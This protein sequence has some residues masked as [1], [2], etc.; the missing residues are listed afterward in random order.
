MGLSCGFMPSNA[1]WHPRHCLCGRIA[2]IRG[3]VNLTL[4]TSLSLPLC[5]RFF[6]S[7][8][9]FFF[10]T[11]ANLAGRIWSA[12]LLVTWSLPGR[13]RCHVIAV[14]QWTVWLPGGSCCG[15]WICVANTPRHFPKIAACWIRLTE[16]VLNLCTDSMFIYLWFITS[17]IS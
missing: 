9:G 15:K 12:G 10:Y 14:A 17:R 16:V 2:G 7:L 13:C 3:V 5:K 1:G 11:N 4:L 6:P 8:G